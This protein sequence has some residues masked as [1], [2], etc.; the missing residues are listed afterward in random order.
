M[1]NLTVRRLLAAISGLSAA[2]AVG[3]FFAAPVWF[4]GDSFRRD[5][6][7]ALEAATGRVWTFGGE[8]VFEPGVRPTVV[9]F[10]IRTPNQ[11]W[12]KRPDLMSIAR[13]EIEGDWLSLLRRRPEAAALYL[14]G[15]ELNLETDSDGNGNWTRA[16][17]VAAHGDPGA[18]SALGRLSDIA[19]I[20]LKNSWLRF[21]SGW[22]ESEQAYPIDVIEFRS[23]GIDSPLAVSVKARVGGQPLSI[24]G[25]L[26]SPAAM[27]GDD[28]FD[29]ALDGRYS[30]RESNAEVNLTGRVGA[31]SDLRDVR[32]AFSLTANS[33]NDVG[34]ISGFA[35]PRDTPVSITAVV[36]STDAGVTLE[37][38][39]LRIGQAI[40]RPSAR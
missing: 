12:G 9:L 15:L 27:F 36:S 5:A 16:S 18:G 10:D 23:A 31:L 4:D 3:V 29:V 21:R 35:L 37:D 2:A 20:T 1:S 28:A 32:L 22:G 7:A 14:D 11:A 34:S 19:T 40:I 30:G 8:A 13:I 24:T 39:V 33:L 38:Y 17:P 26:G 25:E 6:R